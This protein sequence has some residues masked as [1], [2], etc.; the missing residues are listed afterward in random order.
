LFFA[1][2]Q[3]FYLRAYDVQTGE[4]LWKYSLP[5]G[6]SATP[7]TYVSPKTGRQYVLVSAGGAA[8]SPKTGDS[9]M[10]FALPEANSH[11]ESK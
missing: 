8:R 11:P 9:V 1:G 4:E 6:S 2:T 10:A 3:D 5:V 7:I